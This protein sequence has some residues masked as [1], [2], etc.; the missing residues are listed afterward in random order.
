MGDDA[1][2]LFANAETAV[3]RERTMRALMGDDTS[4]LEEVAEDVGKLREVMQGDNWAE[5]QKALRDPKTGDA[6]GAAKFRQLAEQ[7]DWAVMS[8]FR[9]ALFKSQQ[10]ALDFDSGL[11]RYVGTRKQRRLRRTLRNTQTKRSLRLKALP[12]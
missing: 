11:N 2:R 10:I 4:V 6:V 3:A 8:Q 12:Q 7:T 9:E 5:I 1:I